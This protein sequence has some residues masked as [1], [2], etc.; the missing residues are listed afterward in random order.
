MLQKYNI[1][2]YVIII[3]LVLV[4][5]SQAVAQCY[6]PDAC[7]SAAE[8]QGLQQGGAGYDFTGTFRTKGCYSYESGKYIRK[9]F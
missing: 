1:L 8:A 2:F 6:T 4:F 7:A 5:P 9:G 3:S